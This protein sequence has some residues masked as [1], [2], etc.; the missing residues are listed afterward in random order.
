M[1]LSMIAVLGY[2]TLS[3]PVNFRARADIK[4]MG[5]KLQPDT[6]NKSG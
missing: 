6:T 1:V 2:V 4:V 5:R 3:V